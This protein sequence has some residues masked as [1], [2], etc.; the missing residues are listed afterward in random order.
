[1]AQLRRSPAKLKTALHRILSRDGCNIVRLQAWTMN[2]KTSRWSL[3]SKDF[4][5]SRKMKLRLSS[6]L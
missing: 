3:D 2:Q 1:M 4:T 6:G 5:F